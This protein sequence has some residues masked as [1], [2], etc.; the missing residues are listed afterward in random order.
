MNLC[1]LQIIAEKLGIFFFF[2]FLINGRFTVAL[3]RILCC[4]EKQETIEE[5]NVYV[6]VCVCV[7]VCVCM[8]VC[9]YAHVH[10]RLCLC[11]NIY[12]CIHISVCRHVEVEGQPLLWFL[13][14]WQPC[15]LETG[16]LSGLSK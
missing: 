11:M 12:V 8:C 6:A 16:S 4:A 14:C 5:L 13:S 7:C 15:P 2:F 9:V 10:I 3:L 1:K